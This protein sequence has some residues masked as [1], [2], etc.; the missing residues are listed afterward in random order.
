MR[1]GTNIFLLFTL[2]IVVVSAWYT[3]NL[4]SQLE[5]EERK[6]M[7]IWAEATRQFI[8]AD[9]HTDID[10]VSEIIEHNTTIPVYMVDADG[11]F[12]LSR[13]V[14]EPKRKVNEFYQKK[15]A[16]LQRTQTPIEVRISDDIVQYIYYEDSNLLRQLYFFPYVQFAI[17]FVF[18]LLALYA[19]Y[20]MQRS[21]QN[22]VWVG[23]SKE[24]AHQLGTPISSLLAWQQL[25]ENKYPQDSLLPEM[26]KDINR[27]QTIAE[28]FSKVGSEP[29]LLPANLHEVLSKCIEYMQTRTSQKV[30][31]Q[32]RCD[33]NIEVNI[34]I[35]L[36]EWVIENLCKNAVDAME[37]V[38]KITIE[39]LLDGKLVKIDVS[40]TGKGIPARKQNDVFKPGYTTKKRGW[41]LGLSLAKRIIE[42][43]HKGKIYV[44][45]SVVGQGTVFR[46]ELKK[47]F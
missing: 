10:F 17:L 38:G 23:L 47:A 30:I 32:L 42:Q 15:I 27:L 4:V 19:L 2:L 21:E 44:L 40:D 9:E 33:E 29:E 3:N 39:A 36:F 45:N 46:I 20:T 5:D 22:R 13:N 12:L 16:H 28:R 26:N 6:K 37:G 1:R 11:N 41:G 34:S 14:R 43:Y 35:P 8:L 31:Y 18:L 25:L 7:E 24:T